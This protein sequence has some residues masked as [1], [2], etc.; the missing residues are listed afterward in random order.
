MLHF[1]Q[2]TKRIHKGRTECLERVRVGLIEK[3]LEDYNRS[4]K[5]HI[6]GMEEHKLQKQIAD[7]NLKGRKDVTE[8]PGK[9]WSNSHV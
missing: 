6:D 9:Y 1:R 8:Y 3:R 7:Y 2:S 5:E 4:W